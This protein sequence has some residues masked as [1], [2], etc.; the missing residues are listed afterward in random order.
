[1]I[2]AHLVAEVA[3]L[4]DG[5]LLDPTI[6]Y[7]TSE[8]LTATPFARAYA[9]DAAM[10]FNLKKLRIILRERGIGH[11]VVKKR[12]SPLA[13]EALERDLRLTGAASCIL[14]LTKV[15][16]AHTVLIGQLAENRIPVPHRGRG[17]GLG[18]FNAPQEETR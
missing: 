4:L 16:G 9:I 6:A 13:P 5:A 15:A 8:T 3:A 11:V 7:I 12:G 1:M 10:P 17:T 18:R 2:R 14:F